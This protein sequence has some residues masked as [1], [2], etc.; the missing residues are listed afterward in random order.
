MVLD[1]IAILSEQCQSQVPSS[2]I[3]SLISIESGGNDL[4]LA[5]VGYS[6]FYQPKKLTFAIRLIKKLFR[7]GYSFS[8]GLMQINSQHYTHYNLN[9]F[10]V[11]DPCTNIKIGADIY[12]DCY[13]RASKIYKNKTEREKHQYA[14]SCYFSGNFKTGF[15]FPKNKPYVQ[16]FDEALTKY[17]FKFEQEN[18]NEKI[19]NKR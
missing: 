13:N 19:S 7:K 10:D 15:K 11:F 8:A 1:N 9:G 5:V 2:V 3:Q 14:S 4:A 16:R 6:G 12:A 18:K 17:N